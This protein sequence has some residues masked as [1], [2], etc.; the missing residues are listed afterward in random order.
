MVLYVWMDDGKIYCYGL[1]ENRFDLTEQVHT[2]PDPRNVFLVIDG[3]GLP[4]PISNGSGFGPSVDDW[5]EEH[6]DLEM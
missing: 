5:Q 1:G 6:H 2:A 4:R 3:L